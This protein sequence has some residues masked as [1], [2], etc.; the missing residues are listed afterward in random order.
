MKTGMIYG[1]I[2][3]LILILALVGMMFI[4]QLDHK[5][6]MEKSQE[7]Q[8]EE[9]GKQKDEKDKTDIAEAKKYLRD[10]FVILG[11]IM[12]AFWQN[13]FYYNGIRLRARNL[14]RLIL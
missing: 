8:D 5:N 1:K 7:K 6:N 10:L 2:W 11:I 12:F 13:I 3:E 4:L 14:S 9:T